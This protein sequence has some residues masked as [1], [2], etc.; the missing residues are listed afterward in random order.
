M[1][2]GT[3]LLNH[4]VNSR[5]G[6]TNADKIGDALPSAVCYAFRLLK[7]SAGPPWGPRDS[8]RKLC[9]GNLPFLT[10]SWLY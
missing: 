2:R 6:K 7:T 4:F 3:P 5:K 8:A 10:A 1:V 9:Q